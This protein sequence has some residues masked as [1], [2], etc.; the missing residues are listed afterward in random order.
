[1]KKYEREI[2]DLLENLD[3]F[4]PDGPPP[5][6]ERPREREPEREVRRTRPVGVMPQPVP[7]RPRRS[8]GGR[9][10][11]W[12]TEH[13]VGAGLRWM[14]AGI[15]LLVVA[16]IIW[17]NFPGIGWVAQIIGALGG[18]VF[19]SPLLVRFFA[20]K[21][22]DNDNQS[23]WR[24]QAVSDDKFNWNSVKSWFGR[25]KPNDPWNDRNKRNRW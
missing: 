13:H 25:K 9:I 24:G 21:D 10:N 1:M 18:L 12:L 17:Q 4:V 20:G 23:Y 22:L 14:L 5:E 7:I 19:L 16:M 6:K 15:G 8:L 3:S 2:R 11:E